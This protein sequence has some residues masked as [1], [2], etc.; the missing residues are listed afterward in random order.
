MSVVATINSDGPFRETCTSL[1]NVE[2]R[3]EALFLQP[4]WFIT[5]PIDSAVTSR[6]TFTKQRPNE[7]YYQCHYTVYRSLVDL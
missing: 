7:E 3:I 2:G 4:C 6:G 5:D 1:D